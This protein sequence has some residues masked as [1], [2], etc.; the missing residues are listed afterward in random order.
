[1]TTKTN[2]RGPIAAVLTLA[3]TFVALMIGAS[4]A[5]AAGA[6]F[7]SDLDKT[8][9]PSNS[10]PSHDCFMPGKCTWTQNEAYGNPG[11]ETAPY[12][13]KLRKIKLIA[14][15]PGK[16][17]LQIVKINKLG[18]VKLKRRGPKI[19]YQGQSPQN[20]NSGVYNVE[21]FKTRVKIKKGERLA[22]KTASTSALRCSSGG[23]NTL[24]HSPPLKKGEKRTWDDDDGCWMLIEAKVKK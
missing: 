23:D 12:S 4:G 16:F 7:G 22:I 10:V 20:W 1:M 14:G 19:H 6:W 13:G 24:L 9:Q 11:G 3:A 17:R 8:V 15:E 5:Q 2:S 18:D 21:K